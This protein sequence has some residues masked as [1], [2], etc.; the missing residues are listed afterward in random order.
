MV[1]LDRF[2][3]PSA[4][5]ATTALQELVRALG[6]R[7]TQH[8]IQETLLSHPDFPNLLSLSEVLN[9]WNIDNTAL[10]LNT[11]EQLRELPL[12]FIAHLNHK[13]GWYVTV[14]A[15]QRDTIT[16]TDSEQGRVR[17]PL[18]DFEKQWSG[19]VLLA[20]CSPADTNGQTGEPD[21]ATK[22]KQEQLSN[23]RGPVVLIGILLTF[24]LI[25]GS[26]AK[27]FNSPDW[28]LL[29][30][31]VTGLILS[32]LLVAKQLGSK[33][34]L[35]DRLCS[36]GSQTNCDD[37]LNSP[38][39]KMWG[40]LSWADVGLLYFAAS[41]ITVL[42]TGSVPDLRPLIYVMALLALPYTLFSIY[43]QALVIRQWCTLCLLVQGVLL[44]E[45]LVAS[46]QLVNLPD[47]MQPYLI[48]FIAFLLPALLW[49]LVKPL[50]INQSKHRR[51]Y[52][53]LMAFKRDPKLFR[54]LLKKQP[55][56]LPI[57]D[58]LHLI[59]LGNPDA[60]HTVTIVTNPYC[61][62]CAKAH[63]ELEGLLN[64]N[65]NVKGQ[66]IFSGSDEKARQVSTHM[67]ALSE[68]EPMQKAM[69]DW[70]GQ[71][72]KKYDVWTKRYPVNLIQSTVLPIVESHRLWCRIAGIT[73]TPTIYVDGYQL[74]ESYKLKSLRWLI[75]SLELVGAKTALNI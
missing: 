73:A 15:L 5:N 67:I 25:I 59:V 24:L 20:E 19:I 3:T 52:A 13:G 4:D 74:P 50:L 35:T 31:K 42:T 69:T 30:T 21:Y 54:A 36:I 60:K 34:A 38:A 57:P 22:R 72:T 32:S 23:L 8:T 46:S 33:N 51:E 48:L 7:V 27:E 18:A 39:A 11:D 70:Y 47:A 66:L 41:L 17:M 16:Y 53:E 65:P 45:G 26:V 49:V 6:A 68:Q 58:D 75:N 29:F 2:F 14:T 12:P 63:A 55:Q 1:L 71:Q 43:Y 9:R 40:W 28:L 56:M 61:G 64:Q 62:P 10:Q 37:V 44:L